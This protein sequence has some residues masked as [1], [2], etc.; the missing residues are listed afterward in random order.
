[1]LMGLCFQWVY[2]VFLGIF[3]LG[4]V[5]CGAAQSSNMLIVGRAISGLG[6][7]GL[8]NGAY[9]IISASVPIHKAP[10]LSFM[11][12]GNDWLLFLTNMCFLVYVG[13]LM[14]VSQMG[15]LLGPAL[16]G[17]LTQYATW[18]WCKLSNP[19]LLLL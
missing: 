10:G 18:R 16:G 12:T 8:L 17:V 11:V 3:E 5:L 4:S 14:G 1:M 13:I 15:M 9:T 6:G 19:F 2:L 7:S